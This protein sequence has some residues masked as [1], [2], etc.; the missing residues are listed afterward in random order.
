MT[1]Y[2]DTVFKS[3]IAQFNKIHIEINRKNHFWGGVVQSVLGAFIFAFLLFLIGLM[4]NFSKEGGIKEI[5]RQWLE[6]N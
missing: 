5:L 1:T 3:K 6:G 4:I 2:G